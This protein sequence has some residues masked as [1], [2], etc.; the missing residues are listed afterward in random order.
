MF[1]KQIAFS[2]KRLSNLWIWNQTKN[3]SS[4]F[5]HVRLREG[6]KDCCQQDIFLWNVQW[7]GRERLSIGGQ[8]V[9]F[10]F[11]SISWTKCWFS[12]CAM[13]GT[14]T[15]VKRVRCLKLNWSVHW[16]VC[17]YWKKILLTTKMLLWC[18]HLR[19]WTLAFSWSLAAEEATFLGWTRDKCPARH[20]R[21][22]HESVLSAVSSLANLFAAS[23]QDHTHQ[24]V[25][26][27][28]VSNTASCLVFA[29]IKAESLR[30]FR[31]YEHVSGSE[32]AE[33]TNFPESTKEIQVLNEIAK[34]ESTRNS[35][36]GKVNF[37]AK[38]F[39]L[40]IFKKLQVSHKNTF[41]TANQGMNHFG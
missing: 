32:V 20:T 37:L 29:L 6:K 1:A 31:P 30:T 18:F 39:W 21:D 41:I 34:K 8:N 11:V 10:L 4:C 5:V 23:D 25:S 16:T 7:K 35:V 15:R 19:K 3:S 38:W 40:F 9:H 28:H 12:F 36:F 27:H 14:E 13:A 17:N 2:T 22:L 33:V 24:H 26:L